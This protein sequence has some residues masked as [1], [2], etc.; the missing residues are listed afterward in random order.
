MRKTQRKRRTTELRNRAGRRFVRRMRRCKT[1]EGHRAIWLDLKRS[2]PKLYGGVSRW[3]WRLEPAYMEEMVQ[4]VFVSTSW[5]WTCAP[6][7]DLKTIA[8]WAL[9]SAKG[10]ES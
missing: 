1:V 9:R 3:L 7:D 10:N 5:A 4:R 8:S 6:L 2:S